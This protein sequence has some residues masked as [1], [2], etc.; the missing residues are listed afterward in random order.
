M[1]FLACAHDG[2]AAYQNAT[3][4]GRQV[5]EFEAATRPVRRRR[6]GGHH[7]PA[8]RY[9]ITTTAMAILSGGVCYRTP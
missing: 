4:A 1:H 6:G 9:I 2:D 5:L 3:V 8:P 7:R